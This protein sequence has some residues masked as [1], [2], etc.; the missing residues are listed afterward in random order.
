M[1]EKVQAGAYQG[2]MLFQSS[3]GLRSGCSESG[4]EV[5]AADLKQ[6]P[7]STAAW[8]ADSMSE[9]WAAAEREGRASASERKEGR[10]AGGV[11]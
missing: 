11:F 3:P 2:R 7:V 4:Q 9:V 10:Q 8:K 5:R 1:S 6:A